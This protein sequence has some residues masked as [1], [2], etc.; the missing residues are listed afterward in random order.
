MKEAIFNDN[1]RKL[2]V[3]HYNDI[4]AEDQAN[5]KR[6]NKSLALKLFNKDAVQ[7]DFFNVREKKVVRKDE[8]NVTEGSLEF[9]K[10]IKSEGSVESSPDK[11]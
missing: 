5:Q 2:I 6:Q 11:A 7:R 4:V 8:Q 10:S 3:N 1:L 9:D